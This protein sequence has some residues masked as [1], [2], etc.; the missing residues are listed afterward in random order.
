MGGKKGLKKIIKSGKNQEKKRLKN[1]KE[2]KEKLKIFKELS[3]CKKM[4]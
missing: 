1:Q 2:R 3:D 4:V